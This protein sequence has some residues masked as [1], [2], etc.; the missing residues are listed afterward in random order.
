MNA[1]RNFLK[2]IA[3]NKSSFNVQ[4]YIAYNLIVRYKASN[5]NPKE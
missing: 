1:R 4:N 5:I 3:K 2:I